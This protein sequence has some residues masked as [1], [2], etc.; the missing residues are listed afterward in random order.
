MW[1]SDIS[2]ADIARP[3]AWRCRPRPRFLA[4]R[5]Q[6]VLVEGVNVRQLV[7]P[8]AAGDHLHVAVLLADVGEGDPGGDHVVGLEPPVGRI[9]VPGDEAGAVRLLDEEVGGP[10]QD[11]GADRVLDRVE[12][13]RVVPI[14]RRPGNSRF[15]V[16]QCLQRLPCLPSWRSGVR[17]PFACAGQTR[18]GIEAVAW[19]ARRGRRS[20][21][22]LRSSRRAL[23]IISILAGTRL[24]GG[25]AVAAARAKRLLPGKPGSAALLRRVANEA[26]APDRPACPADQARARSRVIVKRAAAGSVGPSAAERADR[27]G[28]PPCARRAAAAG[29]LSVRIFPGSAPV[30]DIPRLS[31]CC[32][33]GARVPTA[34]RRERRAWPPEE[35]RASC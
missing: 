22:S 25:I 32:C 12:H 21:C 18:P 20:S 26:P 31:A 30:T 35:P 15:V 17:Y 2:P 4:A 33:S 9:L 5:E 23:R 1:C 8:V 19:E 3:T 11:V 13:L 34:D 27:I 24:R 29:R 6:V 14:E 10:A 28:Q 7:D 16:A